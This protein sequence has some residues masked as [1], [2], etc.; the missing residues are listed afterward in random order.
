MDVQTRDITSET[1]PTFDRWQAN[2]DEHRDR[3]VE[4][5]GADG[6]AECEESVHILRR[7]WL[8]GTLGYGL[9]S[10]VR[11]SDPAP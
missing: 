11:G 2:L 6:V 3:V 8:D 5:I 1:L 10:A 7:F 9:V 4:L